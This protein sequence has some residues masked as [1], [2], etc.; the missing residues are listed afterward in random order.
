MLGL[1]IAVI[2]NR[3]RYGA[4]KDE[5]PTSNVDSNASRF[6]NLE[7]QPSPTVIQDKF[8]YRTNNVLLK[9]YDFLPI[10]PS[11]AVSLKI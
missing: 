8:V 1:V 4:L 6:W 5:R 10:A 11:K 3:F 7:N 2:I 9:Y